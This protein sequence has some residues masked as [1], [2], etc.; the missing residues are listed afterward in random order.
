MG[1]W[2]ALV[3]V[4]VGVVVA[5]CSSSYGPLTAD[6]RVKLLEPKPGSR[7]TN[8]VTL[9]WK[10]KF[11]PGADSGLWFVVYLDFAPAAPGASTLVAA[12]EPCADVPACLASGAIDGPY[13]FLT[14]Q[15]EIDAGDLPGGAG[16]EHRYTVVLV[17]EQGIR[18][19]D[20]AWNAAFTVSS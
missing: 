8:P 15:H 19:G 20:V 2:L 7:V 10:S 5:A 9:R 12:A 17:D 4:V 3:V 11:E 13:V 6:T 1:W 16:P 18:Q 14:D